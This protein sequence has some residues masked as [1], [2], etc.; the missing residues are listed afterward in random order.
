[1]QAVSLPLSVSLGACQALL[2]RPGHGKE[3]SLVDICSAQATAEQEAPGQRAVLFPLPARVVMEMPALLVLGST[4]WCHLATSSHPAGRCVLK[5]C[6]QLLALGHQTH[7][8][9]EIRSGVVTKAQRLCGCGDLPLS[10]LKV[11]EHQAD[12]DH[13]WGA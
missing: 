10:A 7:R 13:S 4:S 9:C 12:L 1:M 3:P 8:G 11:S 5:S 2:P 6:S